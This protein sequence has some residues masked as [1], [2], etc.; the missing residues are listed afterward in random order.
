M[1]AYPKSGSSRTP[2]SFPEPCQPHGGQQRRPWPAQQLLVLTAGESQVVMRR[3]DILLFEVAPYC[4][5]TAFPS[6][7]IHMLSFRSWSIDLR[8]RN[9]ALQK[10][11]QPAAEPNHPFESWP[12]AMVLVVANPARLCRLPCKKHLKPHPASLADRIR[13]DLRRPNPAPPKP[14]R[15]PRSPPA[16]SGRARSPHFLAPTDRM[17]APKDSISSAVEMPA[18]L[19][20]FSESKS[21]SAQSAQAAP[22]IG[23]LT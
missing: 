21:S 12:F 2:A 9:L 18:A 15:T 22:P 6:N 16:D 7:G 3:W 8:H 13:S 4:I 17:R 14:K 10:L 1:L 11:C 20:G 5:P 23:K 19:A